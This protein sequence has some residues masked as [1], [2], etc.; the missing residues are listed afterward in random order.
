MFNLMVSIGGTITPA[1]Y[2]ITTTGAISVSGSLQGTNIAANQNI[3][4]FGEQT[5][6]YRLAAF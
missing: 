3:A 1:S 5:I 6:T 4:F 2:T